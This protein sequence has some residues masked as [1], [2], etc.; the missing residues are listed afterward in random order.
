M[1]RLR[2]WPAEGRDLT[3][4]ARLLLI[5][6][7]AV[8]AA[9]AGEPGPRLFSALARERDCK[10]AASVIGGGF[11]TAP[12]YAA[13]INGMAMHV[14][15]YEPMWNPPNHALSTILPALLALA[16][17]IE[18]EGKPPRGAR[19]LRALLKGIEAQG[20]LRL[21]SQQIEPRQLT[22]HPPGVIGPI[23][24]PDGER[25]LDDQGPALRQ[26]CH[27]RSRGGPA[28]RSGF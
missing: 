18:A 4:S 1:A 13:R 24:G 7:L 28:G 9:G 14:L 15:D 11:A 16:E 5:D 12:E 25:R 22:L 17:T 23:A 3:A 26:R 19:V 21:A 8:A 10:P 6:G 27:A 20:R 2:A